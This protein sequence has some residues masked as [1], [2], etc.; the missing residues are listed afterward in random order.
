MN[1]TVHERRSSAARSSRV[2]LRAQRSYAKFGPPLVVARKWEIALSHRSGLSRKASGDMCVQGKPTKIGCSTFPM[3]PMSWKSGSHPTPDEPAS[4]SKPARMARSL[5]ITFAWLTITPLGC[6][7]EPDVYWRNASVS[8]EMSGAR[9]A[10]AAP[11]SSASVAIQRSSESSGACARR[12]S[13]SEAISPV[14]S[15]NLAP[16]SRAIARRR[17]RV[18]S[19]CAGFGGYV[20]TATTPA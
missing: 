15:T 11:G 5:A 2:A 17:G 18:R 10:E 6:P 8:P 16:A 9:H 13:E 14:V 20:G 19:S 3:S 1:A 7:V 4:C 12:A